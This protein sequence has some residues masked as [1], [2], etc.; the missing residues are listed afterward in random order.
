VVCRARRPRRGLFRGK[1]DVDWPEVGCGI[2]AELKGYAVDQCTL[3]MR[4]LRAAAE[5]GE[6]RWRTTRL[7]KEGKTVGELKA[8]VRL[9]PEDLGR[10]TTAT[11][12][13]TARCRDG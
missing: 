5:G 12:F 2:V 9:I 3:P 4:A 7:R 1:D 8:P 6:H 13:A 11:V 10:V